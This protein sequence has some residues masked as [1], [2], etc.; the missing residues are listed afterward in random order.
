M[1]FPVIATKGPVISLHEN[2]GDLRLATKTALKSG[3]FASLRVLDARGV[4]YRVRSAK[5]VRDSGRRLFS[6]WFAP[7]LIE[8]D[9]DIDEGRQLSVEQLREALTK[10]I[11]HDL[12]SW[13]SSGEKD[14]VLND[15]T[16]ADS[17]DELW[18][19]LSDVL[20]RGR[21]SSRLSP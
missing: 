14:K 15:L 11:K 19:A 3:W 13:E 8:V 17:I 20:T 12:G 18:K 4:E 21:V 2:E 1:K 16:R 9:L 7:R 6:G 10:A 5:Y